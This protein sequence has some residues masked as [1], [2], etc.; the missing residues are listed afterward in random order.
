M[1][2]EALP[3]APSSHP[4]V[5]DNREYSFPTSLRRAVDTLFTYQPIATTLQEAPQDEPT[6]EF[7]ELW[8]QGMTTYLEET[9]TAAVS[10]CLDVLDRFKAGQTV[11]T[12]GETSG[13]DPYT[14]AEAAYGAR[15]EQLQQSGELRKPSEI[16]NP[17]DQEDHFDD[18]ARLYKDT[19]LAMGLAWPP[20]ARDDEDLQE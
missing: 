14:I 19:C 20:P 10:S 9:A 3:L 2:V 6:A 7:I 4:R 1:P 12:R 15:I 17:Y 18:L 8:K 13:I 11:R 5:E 16:T